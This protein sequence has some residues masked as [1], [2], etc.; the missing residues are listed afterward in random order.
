MEMPNHLIFRNRSKR[1]RTDGRCSGHPLRVARKTGLAEEMT[2]CEQGNDGFFSIVRQHRHPHC[3]VL[4]IHD[5]GG[6][7]ALSENHMASLVSHVLCENTGPVK[8]TVWRGGWR[9]R[10]ADDRG[11]VSVLVAGW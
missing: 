3:A 7:I 1:R 5:C 4:H 8:R 11:A 2:C 10:R 6:R 9:P